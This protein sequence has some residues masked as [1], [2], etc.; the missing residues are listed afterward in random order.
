M[1]V[2]NTGI[3]V[4]IAMKLMLLAVLTVWFTM[5]PTVRFALNILMNICQFVVLF[6]LLTLIAMFL[7]T[8]TKF[9]E[10]MAQKVEQAHTTLATC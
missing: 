8:N 6:P 4:S 10:T 5:I 7:K 9:W 3:N 1:E 2:V